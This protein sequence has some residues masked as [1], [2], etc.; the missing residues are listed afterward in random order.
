MYG[1]N[2]FKSVHWIA[3]CALL[4]VP[5]APASAADD[6]AALY[7]KALTAGRKKEASAAIIHLKNAVQ[8]DPS[9]LAA[10]VLLG[11]MYLEVADPISAE[12]EFLRAEQ[13]GADRALIS[14][15]L[16]KAYLAQDKYDL[17]LQNIQPRGFNAQKTSEIQVLRGHAYFQMRQL[18]R[19]LEAFDEAATADPGN[20]LAIVGRATVLVRRGDI[21]NATKEAAKATD[22]APNNAESWQ[23]KASIA[24]A[25]GKLKEAVTDY[26]RAIEIEPRHLAARVA[27]AGALMDLGN[28][29]AAAEDVTFLRKESPLDPRAIYLQAVVEAQAGKDAESRKTLSEAVSAVEKIRPEII[30]KHSPTLL[31]AGLINFSEGNRE[32]S[33]SYL[34]KYVTQNPSQVGARKLLGS[35]L[36][37]KGDAKEAIRIL[38]PV[39]KASPNDY[40]LLT[41]MGTAHM[42]ARLHIQASEYFDR[43]ASLSQGAAEVTVQR[44]LNTLGAGREDDAVADLAG[45]FERKGNAERAGV[46]LAMLQMKQGNYDAAVKV[47]EKLHNSEPDNLT[48]HNLLAAAH[49]SAG[50]RKVARAT[51]E[52]ILSKNPSFVTAKVNLA[53]L[54]SLEG[55]PSAAIKRMESVL[56]DDPKNVYALSELGHI[57]L[58]QGNIGEA[59]SWFEKVRALDNRFVSALLALVDAYLTLGKPQDALKVAQ[60]AE[61]AAPDNPQVSMTLS[62]AYVA[63]DHKNEARAI[64][65]RLS[66]QSGSQSKLL[67][68]IARAQLT[69]DDTIGANWSLRKAI[70]SDPKFVPA[71]VGLIEVENGLGNRDSAAETLAKL[72]AR[73]PNN[74]IANR[75]QGDLY[76]SD[77]QYAKAIE[78][79]RLATSGKDSG[80]AA[81]RL[82]LAYWANGE[83][84]QAVQRQTR[85]VKEHPN[86]LDARMA[87]AEGYLRLKDYAKA[88]GQY[89]LIVKSRPNDANMLNNLANAYAKLNDERALE[90]ADRA[91]KLA[92]NN[93]LVADTYGWQLVRSGQAEKALPHLRNA[94]SRASNDPEIRYHIG[95]ALAKLARND[96]AVVELETAIKTN[97]K[98]EGIEDAR[99]LISALKK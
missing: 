66:T 30:E 22:I 62:R 27:R 80:L 35:L 20:I 48:V 86:D 83:G 52:Q 7:E 40:R 65:T 25:T 77:R 55:N 39:L 71:Y 37:D 74:P 89:E 44:A 49:F 61:T 24:H 5:C 43:A 64:L 36:V 23:I 76:M 72:R 21:A 73:H 15:P 14:I 51:Y 87:L 1:I 75:L 26:N 70:E 60:Q 28:Y 96:E 79:Y 32:K 8:K 17:V 4:S 42:K 53:K 57:A 41:L 38:D 33:L 12:K 46:L 90:I 69:A 29:A 54:D 45:I 97:V 56:K 34:S 82:Y 19:A 93:P 6:A 31:L 58:I 85:W 10:Y 16:G 2:A 99:A 68:E 63:V 98:F 50:N 92:P 91:I 11:E 47:T 9:Y 81:Q 59:V 84:E 67:F 78:S 18:D 13:L 88:K 94:H 3:L 95:A